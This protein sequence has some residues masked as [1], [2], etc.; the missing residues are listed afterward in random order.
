MTKH[1]QVVSCSPCRWC[2]L[3]AVTCQGPRTLLEDVPFCCLLGHMPS[4]LILSC[5][6][7][8]DCSDCSFTF[9]G[10]RTALPT[11]KPAEPNCCC[12]A[13]GGA[14]EVAPVATFSVQSK[15]AVRVLP[16]PALCSEGYLPSPD[17]NKI[18]TL[19]NQLWPCC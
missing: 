14:E 18:A 5:P 4:F 7:S 9:C 10:G 1:H 12:S 16:K 15:S 2:F 3:S 6:T 13:V 17:L 19:R 8:S 11:A